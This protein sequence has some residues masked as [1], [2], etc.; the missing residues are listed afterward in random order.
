MSNHL[1]PAGAWDTHI[2][3]F[4]PEKFPYAIPRS[5][6]PQAAQISGYPHVVTGCTSIVVVHASM[7]GSSPAPLLDTLRKQKDMPGFKLRGLATIDVDT[8][9]D[10]ELDELHS[11]GV[12]GARM[13]E[14]AWG[15]GEQ[16][17]GA[18]IIKKVEA[19]AL[20]IARLGWVIG[21]F[22]PLSAWAAMADMI[23]NLDPRVKI[24]ADHFGSTFPGEEETADF[25]ALLSLVRE[26]RLFV[27]ISGFERLYHGNPTGIDSLAV[28]AKALIE[29]GP[30]QIV[31]GSDWPHTQLGVTRKGKT[32]E[33]RLNDIEGFREVDDRGHIKKLREWISDEE[34]WRKFWVTNPARLFE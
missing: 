34:T 20:R 15:H 16:K 4:N 3:V 33:Q 31:F 24:V 30:D 29:A 8:I 13:H 11:A 12:R 32:D 6:T 18:Q 2:H 10:K 22:C 7:Q 27:K 14:M 9:T 25:Q 19:L 28:A 21:I 17:G 5:Y 26:K 23:R 1:V